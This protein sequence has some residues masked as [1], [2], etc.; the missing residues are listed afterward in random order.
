MAGIFGDARKEV[1]HHTADCRVE[2]CTYPKESVVLTD[3]SLIANFD[4][5]QPI[6]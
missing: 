1:Q 2:I 4:L 3:G 6:I 5:H